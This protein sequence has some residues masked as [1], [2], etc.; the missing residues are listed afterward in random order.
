MVTLPFY[1][2]CQFFEF[3]GDTKPTTYHTTGPV[4]FDPR[5]MKSSEDIEPRH[6]Y[7]ALKRELLKKWPEMHDLKIIIAKNLH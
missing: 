1:V 2:Y 5:T 4:T 6:V 3:D 7:P